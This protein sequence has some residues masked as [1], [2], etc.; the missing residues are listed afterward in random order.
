[1]VSNK[2]YL[3]RH[4]LLLNYYVTDCFECFC[5][6]IRPG[7]DD[8]VQRDAR[9]RPRWNDRNNGEFKGR[10]EREDGGERN[11]GFRSSRP[12][13]GG[14]RGGKREYERR[15]GNDKT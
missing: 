10:T 9:S 3:A 1:M 11:G 14:F 12:P 8:V 2:I 5:H 6:I 4:F 13:R 15:S 7:T